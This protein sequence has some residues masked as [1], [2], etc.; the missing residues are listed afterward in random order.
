MSIFQLVKK[1]SPFVKPYKWLVVATLVLTL[2]GS[3][4]AQ[5]NAIVLDWTVDTINGL[6]VHTGTGEIGAQHFDW[7]KAMRILTIITVILL[8]KEV[9]SVVISYAQNFF[10]ERMRVQVSKDLA[11]AAIDRILS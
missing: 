4:I 10:G 8:G 1:I 3:V 9:L 5:V 11:Q 6:I 2:V 7:S